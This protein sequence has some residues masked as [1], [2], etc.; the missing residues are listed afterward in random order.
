MKYSKLPNMY[1]PLML[2]AY[3]QADWI[4][5]ALGQIDELKETQA[6]AL[7]LKYNL[8]TLEDEIARTGKDWRKVL[9]QREKEQKELEARGLL[10]EVDDNMMNAASG[11]A[12]EKETSDAAAA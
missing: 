9:I 1:E 12:R 7:R 10:M 8:S 3:T 4:G 5:A 11:E 2:D 6:A